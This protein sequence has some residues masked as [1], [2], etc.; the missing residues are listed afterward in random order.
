MLEKMPNLEEDV[1]ETKA[2]VQEEVRHLR[3]DMKVFARGVTDETQT[4]TQQ[5]QKMGK[6]NT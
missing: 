4:F 1:D 5:L 3:E 2:C 6:N